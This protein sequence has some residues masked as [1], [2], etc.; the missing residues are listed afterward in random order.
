MKI[1]KI[2]ALGLIAVGALG[3]GAVAEER[4][5]IRGFTAA[6]TNTL[7]TIR[8]LTPGTAGNPES[9]CLPRR[10]MP[11]RECGT[12]TRLTWCISAPARLLRPGTAG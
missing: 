10:K 9:H 2:C 11:C 4:G 7:N 12:D 5:A 3:N 1:A 6:A 8:N